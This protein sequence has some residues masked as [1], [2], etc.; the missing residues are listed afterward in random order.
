[1]ILQLHFNTLAAYDDIYLH[2]HRF[3]KDPRTYLNINQSDSSLCIIDLREIKTRRDILGPLFSRR[4]IMQ[5][6]HVVLSKV[7][8]EFCSPSSRLDQ[9]Y[10]TPYR[11]AGSWSN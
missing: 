3:T 11:S 9:L 5:L 6:E 7:R 10:S 1:M 8:H 2:G 4:A